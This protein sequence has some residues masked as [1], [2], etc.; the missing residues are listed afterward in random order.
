[1][2]TINPYSSLRPMRMVLPPLLHMLVEERAG[3]RRLPRDS[4]SRLCA[5]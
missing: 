5:N 4:S 2:S 3:V 1:M